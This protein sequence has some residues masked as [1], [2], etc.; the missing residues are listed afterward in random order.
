MGNKQSNIT[1]VNIIFFKNS[2]MN[3]FGKPITPN[4]NIHMFDM[5]EIKTMFITNGIDVLEVLNYIKPNFEVVNVL[6]YD[7]NIDESSITL[8][9][10]LDI[11]TIYFANNS[12]HKKYINV[13]TKFPKNVQTFNFI[14]SEKQTNKEKEWINYFSA[15]A[16]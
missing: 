15:N 8:I 4:K 9:N 3:Y 12:V 16:L 11:N 6:I 1:T 7:C 5:C 10:E 13:L 2:D 14:H